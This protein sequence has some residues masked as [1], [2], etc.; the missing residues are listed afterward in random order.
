MSERAKRPSLSIGLV[1]VCLARNRA[2]AS[3]CSACVS[4]ANRFR[5]ATLHV[6]GRGK[7]AASMGLQPFDY[8]G[9]LAAPPR[10]VR[11][12]EGPV[13]H[14][15][16]ELSERRTRIRS[17]GDG[18]ETRVPAT[19]PTTA[20]SKRWGMKCPFGGTGC[21]GAT[22]FRS[23]ISGAEGRHQLVSGEARHTPHGL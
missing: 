3:Q 9:S 2:K 17:V 23:W 15:E 21:E 5:R 22:N 14:G 16:C 7:S 1:A 13:D 12:R 4:N 20:L 6:L 10:A 18:S 11:G 8:A 19:A